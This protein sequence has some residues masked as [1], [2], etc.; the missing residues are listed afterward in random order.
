[1]RTLLEHALKNEPL[2]DVCCDHGYVGIKALE[3]GHHKEVHFVDQIPHIMERLQLLINQS[4]SN[5]LKQQSYYLYTLAGQDISNDIYGTLLVAG[6]GGTTI[7]TILDG[8]I[9]KKNLKAKRLLLSP[10]MDE[11]I[12]V[13]Y[14]ESENFKHHY[15]LKEKIMMPEGPRERPLY[16]FDGH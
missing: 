2:W 13:N 5:T 10:H 4:R 8:L 12:F 11:K 15:F 9:T 16:I 3:S 6:V 14:I 1:M 7:V